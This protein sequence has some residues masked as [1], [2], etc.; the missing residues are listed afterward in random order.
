VLGPTANLVA[1]GDEAG[2]VYILHLVTPVEKKA[3]IVVNATPD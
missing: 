1:Y 2:N 3:V